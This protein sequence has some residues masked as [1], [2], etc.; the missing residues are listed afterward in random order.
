M[1][2]TVTSQHVSERGGPGQD[3]LA[4]G[5]SNWGR[6]FVKLAVLC[7]CVMA[8]FALTIAVPFV[9]RLQ[10]RIQRV[11]ASTQ[12]G[13]LLLAVVIILTVGYLL[14]RNAEVA[15]AIFYGIGFFKGDARL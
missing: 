7:F 2:S 3:I 8:S 4:P 6:R 1:R 9:A 14:L 5:A 12:L 10:P 13:Y 15:L 11:F